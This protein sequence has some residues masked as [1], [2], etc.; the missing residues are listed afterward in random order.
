VKSR[1][2]NWITAALL[3]LVASFGV[4]VARTD[5]SLRSSIVWVDSSG[6]AQREIVEPRRSFPQSPSEKPN[7]LP[8][9]ASHARVKL[10]DRSL[11]QRPPPVSFS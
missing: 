6:E 1:L 2:T 5:V 11:F 10:L 4:P 3:L 9:S 8:G 7:A